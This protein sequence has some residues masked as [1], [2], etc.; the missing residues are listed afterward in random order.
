[1]VKYTHDY[2]NLFRAAPF[3][4]DKPFCYDHHGKLLKEVY[5]VQPLDV[6]R[7]TNIQLLRV[8]DMN[9]PL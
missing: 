8:T 5:Y 2:Y 4:R 9:E 7:L 3:V 1:M 6:Y